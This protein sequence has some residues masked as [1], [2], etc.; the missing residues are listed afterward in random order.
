MPTMY[1]IIVNYTAINVSVF[2]TVAGEPSEMSGWVGQNKWEHLNC[3]VGKCF[4]GVKT[5]KCNHID[6]DDCASSPCVWGTC[7]DS[8]TYYTCDCLVGWT[9]IN[10]D[11]GAAKRKAIPLTLLQTS[12]SAPMIHVNTPWRTRTL[13][14]A[15]R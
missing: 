15:L 13:R 3:S 1:D 14:S 11:T 5:T 8:T 4:F 10:C 7:Y 2:N 6:Y 9:G 12:S